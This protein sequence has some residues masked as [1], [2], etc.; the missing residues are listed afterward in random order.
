MLEQKSVSLGSG[1]IVIQQ[2][3]TT[4]ALKHS[5]ILG[6]L[7][8]G[9]AQGVE[10]YS[11][12]IENWNINFGRIISGM[13]DQLDPEKSPA[14]IKELVQQSVIQPTFT[15]DWF[16]ITFSG[17]LEELMELLKAILEFNYGGLIE[18]ARKKI[19][20]AFTSDISS[21]KESEPESSAG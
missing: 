4:L 2:L 12:K 10:S 17:N 3:G 11:T 9:A 6:N 19:E 13:I 1:E 5:V 21:E 8:G 20:A 7:F 15:D 14:W 16:D 18:Y